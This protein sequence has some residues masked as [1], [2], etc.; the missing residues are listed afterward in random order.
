[1]ANLTA[2]QAASAITDLINSRSSSPRHDELVAIIAQTQGHTPL[3]SAHA[4]R[5]E[6][7]RLT[8]ADHAAA[9]VWGEFTLDDESA[10][11]ISA[12]AAADATDKALLEFERRLWGRPAKWEDL[13]L[14]AEGPPT[15]G[16]ARSPIFP[17]FFLN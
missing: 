3:P 6:W 14:L 15:R 13:P 16:R 1:M 10:A 17:L 11:A 5:M 8:S 4:E 12:R 2:T 7:R 9:S